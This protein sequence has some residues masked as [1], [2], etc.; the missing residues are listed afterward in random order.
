MTE[1]TDLA[2]AIGA[3]VEDER[4]ESGLSAMTERECV[5]SARTLE[6][7]DLSGA[8]GKTIDAYMRVIDASSADIDAALLE[9]E[10]AD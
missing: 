1:L 5:D 9:R 2:E 6:R 10:T 3:V 4:T 7:S 8:P